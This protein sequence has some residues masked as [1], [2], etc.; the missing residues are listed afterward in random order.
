M[1]NSRTPTESPVNHQPEV[2]QTL[3]VE[4]IG[5]G[6]PGVLYSDRFARFV[7]LC[8]SVEP[9][10]RFLYTVRLLAKI[11]STLWIS[12]RAPP[13]PRSTVS[14]A[15]RLAAIHAVSA[16][17]SRRGSLTGRI[18]QGGC[19][20]V[21]TAVVVVSLGRRGD[22]VGW[23]LQFGDLQEPDR[24]V[25]GGAGHVQPHRGGA[26]RVEADRARLVGRGCEVDVLV[27]H[28]H[29]CGPVPVRDLNRTR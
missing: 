10:S 27:A 12:R 17:L 19:P 3:E 4:H 20:P 25:R 23:D 15:G 7:H 9:C 22:F 21:A 11:V 16:E 26:D 29:P 13:S 28:R 14:A 18:E 8:T 2:A 24:C 6:A 5:D 1:L